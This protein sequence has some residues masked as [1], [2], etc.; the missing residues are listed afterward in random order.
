MVGMCVGVEVGALLGAS[1]LLAFAVG[2]L[3]G[4]TKQ[5]TLALM[6]YEEPKVRMAF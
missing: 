3:V 4:L 5:S 2:I 1:L 6:S